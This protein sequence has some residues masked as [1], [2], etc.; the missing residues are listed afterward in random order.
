[1]NIWCISKYASPKK[2]FDFPSRIFELLTEFEK[3]GN[4]VLLITSDSNHLANFPKTSSIY[5]HEI[6]EKI[7]VSWIKTKKYIKTASVGRVLSWIDFEFKLFFFPL[8]KFS[9]PDVI[10]V[11][12]LSIFSI[13][14]GYYLKV[15]YKCILVFEIRDIWPLTMT[16]DGGFSK[17]HPL[18]ILIGII[19]WFGYKYSDLIVGTMPKLDLHIKNILGYSKP[20]RCIPLGFN[21]INYKTRAKELDQV[22]KSIPKNKVIVGYCG[23]MGITNAL[24]LFFQSIKDHSSSYT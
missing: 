24:D 21:P 14:Y 6:I 8:N 13:I 7:K 20:F 23:S 16:E 15:K 19:E 17:W 12:S 4:E 9:R 1:M 18:V 2:Y 22:Y 10:I 5:N 11:S 3:S